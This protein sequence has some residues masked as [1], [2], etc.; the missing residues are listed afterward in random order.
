M[1]ICRQ[2]AGKTF[3]SHLIKASQPFEGLKKHFKRPRL[4]TNRNLYFLNII[5]E[6]NF[7]F[8]GANIT[9]LSMVTCLSEL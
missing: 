2:S 3:L 5:A 1:Y 4:S 8:L 6:Y 7:L 9:A